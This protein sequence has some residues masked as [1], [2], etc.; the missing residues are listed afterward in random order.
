MAA[1]V[2]AMVAHFV[3]FFGPNLP[4]IE[5]KVPPQHYCFNSAVIANDHC[6]YMVWNYVHIPLELTEWVLKV[7]AN[8]NSSLHQTKDHCSI[9][10]G[11]QSQ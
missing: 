9:V 3:L 7:I 6:M 2:N 1:L 8:Q 4:K 11:S 5:L 10:G